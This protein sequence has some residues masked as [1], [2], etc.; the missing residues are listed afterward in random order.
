MSGLGQDPG[1]CGL[2]HNGG[3]TMD[4]GYGWR[5]HAWGRARK[6]LIPNT[7][8][9]EIVRLRVKRAQALGLEYRTYASIRAASGQD[10]VAFLFSGNALELTPRRVAVPGRV[11]ARLAA[12]DGAAQRI[13]AV[14]APAHPD[15]VDRANPGLLDQVATAPAITESWRA[16]RA[17]LTAALRARG[18]PADGVVLVAATGVEREWC[19]AARLAGVIPADRFF[20]AG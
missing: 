17:R 16:V 9:L 18:M 13:G 20:G 12:L 15:A 19:G 4:P 3:P 8:P 5:K 10:V 11:A 2:G 7:M 14:Y 6:A 1:L